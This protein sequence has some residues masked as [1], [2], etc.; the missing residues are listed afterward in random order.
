MRQIAAETHVPPSTFTRM[1]AGL[2]LRAD[3]LLR[4][5]VWLNEHGDDWHDI[6]AVITIARKKQR[7]T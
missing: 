6:M 2:N 5:L 3:A 1:A 4:I 7:K